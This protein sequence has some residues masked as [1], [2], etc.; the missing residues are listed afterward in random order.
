MLTDDPNSLSVLVANLFHRTGIPEACSIPD[1]IGSSLEGYRECYR[2]IKAE[3]ERVLPDLEAFIK[4][5]S[6]I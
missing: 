1:P 3:I 6:L 5:E 4:K 2:R